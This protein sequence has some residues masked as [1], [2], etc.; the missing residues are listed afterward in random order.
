MLLMMISGLI[1]N[2]PLIMSHHTIY[3]DYLRCF[4]RCLVS[5]FL[6]YDCFAVQVSSPNDAVLQ[7][8]PR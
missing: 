4:F 7:T 6:I 5:S 1:G 2:L 8:Q 3:H